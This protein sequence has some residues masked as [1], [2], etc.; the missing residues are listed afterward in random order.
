MEH[1]RDANGILVGDLRKGDHFGGPGL[2]WLWLGTGGG[3]L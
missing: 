3:G 1:R 2:L